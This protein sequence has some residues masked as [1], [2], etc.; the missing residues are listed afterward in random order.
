LEVQEKVRRINLWKNREEGKKPHSRMTYT[1]GNVHIVDSVHFNLMTLSKCTGYVV[2][3]DKLE[4][5]MMNFEEC[6]RNGNSLLFRYCLSIFLV[7]IVDV[8]VKMLTT[9]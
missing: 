2:S 7:R 3:T 6:G 9:T 1:S 4:L 5:V 8:P